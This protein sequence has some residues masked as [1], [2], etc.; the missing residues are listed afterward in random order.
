MGENTVYHYTS[1]ETFCKIIEGVKGSN[2]T[3]R[4]TDVNYLNDYT[5]HTIAVGLLK[6]KLIAY[7]K[8][9]D[10]GKTKNLATLLNDKR[11]SFFRYDDIEY[12]HPLIISFSENW[13]NLP[14]WNTYA[15][16][17]KGVALGFDKA[18]LSQLGCRFEKCV[19]DTAAY[20]KYLDNN[21][22]KIHGCTHVTKYS[23]E[24]TQDYDSG[25]LEE[26]FKYLPILKDKGY[27]YEQEHRLIIPSKIE[28]RHQLKFQTSETLLKPY[29]EIEIPFEYLT[30]IVLG[31]CLQLE[32]IKGSIAYLLHQKNRGLAFD[33]QDGKIQLRASEIPYRSI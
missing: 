21:I 2:I 29:K 4:A 13:D 5:E 24:F 10:K 19:Y 32:K 20:L 9:L 23:I 30:E 1:L 14:M 28:D 7:D 31:P 17:S 8:S 18:K 11:M 33:K 3:L 25:L 15:D 22:D 6:D 16:N 27:Q 12:L 26:H